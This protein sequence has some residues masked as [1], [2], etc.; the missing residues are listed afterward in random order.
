M[1]VIDLPKTFW[2]KHPEMNNAFV[3]ILTNVK[4]TFATIGESV[5]P[6]IDSYEYM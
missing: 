2:N 5:T 6:L 1:A 4:L 3:E